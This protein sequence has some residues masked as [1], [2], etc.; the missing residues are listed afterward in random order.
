M[1]Q[2]LSV[3]KQ[4]TNYCNNNKKGLYNDKYNITTEIVSIILNKQNIHNYGTIN[5]ED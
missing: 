4:L 1:G 2:D 3:Q 5:C